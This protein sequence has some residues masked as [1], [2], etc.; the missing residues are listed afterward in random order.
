MRTCMSN[1]NLKAPKM[2][3]CWIRKK[4]FK[5]TSPWS[6]LT[7]SEPRFEFSALYIF[8]HFLSICLLCESEPLPAWMLSCESIPVSLSVCSICVCP[9]QRAFA[10]CFL[11][12]TESITWGRNE[13]LSCWLQLTQLT[14]K[15]TLSSNIHMLSSVSLWLII[16]W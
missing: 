9:Q 2:Y 13:G 3:Q 1:N 10:L 14:N 5:S 12:N 15:H 8:C 16:I 7:N 11:N 6:N 4:K